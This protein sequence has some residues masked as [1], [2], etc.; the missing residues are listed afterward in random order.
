MAKIKNIK[1]SYIWFNLGFNKHRE[2]KG[3]YCSV[4]FEKAHKS[5]AEIDE[6]ETKIEA[7]CEGV[8]EFIKWYNKQTKE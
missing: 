1:R 5:I 7:A 4:E 6:K 2:F 8:V 3:W